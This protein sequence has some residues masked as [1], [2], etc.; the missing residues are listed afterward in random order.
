[1]IGQFG[2][3]FYSAYLVADK[4]VVHSKHNDDEQYVWT[5]E[6]GSSFQ[7]APD[8]EGERLTR[9]TKIVLHL[10]K[11][12]L[13]YLE[14]KRI[15]E[16]VKKHSEF[17]GFS[18]SLAVTKEEEKE[19]EEEEEAD[20][21]ADDDKT[22]VEEETEDKKKDKKK[23]KTTTTEFEVLNK[24]KPIWVRKPEEVTKEEYGQFKKENEKNQKNRFFL[25]FFHFQSPLHWSRPSFFLFLC[26]PC[27]AVA[28]SLLPLLQPLS[29][30][31]CRTTGRS[32]WP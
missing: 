11:D 29:T 28:L 10:K 27:C 17:I 19:V 15:K 3:G 4:V 8:T 25:F 12:Q 24:T 31:L 32:T 30:R 6:A 23:V 18:V 20:K 26:S 5:S 16:L 9:G 14:E 7:V 22:K 21:A 2:V 13:E 1:M